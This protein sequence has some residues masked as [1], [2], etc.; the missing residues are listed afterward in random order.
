MNCSA[1][2]Y[3]NFYCALP[4]LQILYMINEINNPFLTKNYRAPM[5]LKL[6]IQRLWRSKLWFLHNSHN[7]SKARRTI[8]SRSW[9]LSSSTYK[10]TIRILIFI[11]RRPKHSWAVPSLGL[12]TDAIPGHLNLTTLI[13]TPTRLVLQTML[14]NMWFKS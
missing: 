12:K 8:T 7:G 4:S 3:S 14:R 11:W 13:S 9:Y 6:W 10:N 5:I 1:C 2:Y